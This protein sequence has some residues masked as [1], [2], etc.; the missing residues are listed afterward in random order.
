[1]NTHTNTLE[2][3][4]PRGVKTITETFDV[5]TQG[6]QEHKLLKRIE[7]RFADGSTM[8]I[9]ATAFCVLG[10]PDIRHPILAWSK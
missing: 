8:A 5:V 4:Q 10:E 3:G 1:M 2:Y 6:D 7:L 9:E